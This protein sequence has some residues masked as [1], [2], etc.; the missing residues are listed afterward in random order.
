MKSKISAITAAVFISAWSL[1]GADAIFD[2]SFDDYTVTPQTAKG[3]KKQKGFTEPDLQLRMYPGVNGKGNALNLGN[4]EMMAYEMKGNFN[5]KEGTIILWIAPHNWEIS[6]PEFQLF[7]YA[8]Q[9]K[10]NFRIA[11]TSVNYISAT[12]TYGIPFQGK[13]SFGTTVKARVEPLDWKAGRYHQVAVT[14]NRE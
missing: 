6:N 9:D 3:S 5:P 10:Y 8:S 11:K 7:F 12:I 13:K 1:T 2:L 14:W 4:S